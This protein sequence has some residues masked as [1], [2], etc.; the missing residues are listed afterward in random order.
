MVETVKN[1]VYFALKSYV[2]HMSSLAVA[3]LARSPRL[4]VAQAC[5]TSRRP[6]ITQKEVEQSTSFCV[7]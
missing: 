6:H 3:K 4:A 5:V 2:S 1:I 7:M